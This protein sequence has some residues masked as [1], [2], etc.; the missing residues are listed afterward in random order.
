MM[1]VWMIVTFMY[2]FVIIFIHTL[3]HILNKKDDLEHTKPMTGKCATYHYAH[4]T[5]LP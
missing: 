2:P 5:I 4:K 3:I 1:D